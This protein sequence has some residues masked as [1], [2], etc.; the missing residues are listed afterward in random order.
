VAAPV[1]DLTEKWK[2]L[3]KE[4]APEIDHEVRNPFQKKS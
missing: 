3:I 4:A 1:D 2:I